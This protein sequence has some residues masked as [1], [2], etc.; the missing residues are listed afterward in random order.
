MTVRAAL[1]AAVALTAVAVIG[2][3]AAEEHSTAAWLF[4][5]ALTPGFAM[6]EAYW[7]S[8]HDPLQFLIAL[9]LNVAFY[10][11]VFAAIGAA[12]QASTSGSVK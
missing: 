8:A 4:D 5:A 12:I 1:G 3:V 2:L 9:T 7:G 10:T 6:P 11:G